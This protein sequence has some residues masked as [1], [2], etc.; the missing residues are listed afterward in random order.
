MKKISIKNILPLILFFSL[1]NS[2]RSNNDITS[3][4][5]T[6]NNS[7]TNLPSTSS[8]LTTKKWDISLRG[9]G[10]VV[11]EIQSLNNQ[12]KLIIRGTGKMKTFSS[13]KNVPFIDYLPFINEIEILEGIT[14]LSSY[15]LSNIN[16]EYVYLPSSI[17]EV[18][19]F[20]APNNVSLLTYNNDVSY[21]SI[22]ENVY[23]YVDKDITTT[24]IYWQQSKSTGDIISDNY[25]FNTLK[26]YWYKD[27]DDNPVIKTKIKILFIGNSFTHRNGIASVS[28]GVPGIFDDLVESLG[29]KS[30]TYAVTGSSWYL[31]KH[32]DKEDECGKQIDKLL[33]ACSDFDFVVLQ[34]QST[35]PIDKYNRFLSGVKALKKKIDSTQDNAEVV[36]YQTWSS[37]YS[38]NERK[39]TI[40]K[41]E[42]ELRSAYEKV[43]EECDITSISFVGKAFAKSYYENS[44]I[45]LWDDDDRHQGYAGAYLSA[46]V[47]ALNI[48]NVDVRN[49][50]FEISP[51]Y[52]D[53]S[54]SKSTYQYL[55]D[56]AYRVVI[57]KEDVNINN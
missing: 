47:H 57:D 9:E 7:S 4:I 31:D 41:M 24:D 14:N 5:S 32:A 16:L 42:Q 10:S 45:Y 18:E 37:P 17:N 43:A 15:V 36:L 49:S 30:E 34:E 1:L 40:W 26:K 29:Y 35:A 46:C 38:V 21:S 52:R 55:K 2:C 48:L 39:T 54:L 6:S 22:V 12:Y 33:N 13:E 51:Q 3:N 27:K 50:T 44:D 20:A 25:K 56:I 53:Y 19:D 8:S 28:S 11:A 23:K